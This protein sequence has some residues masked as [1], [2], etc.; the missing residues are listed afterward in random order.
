ML[1]RLRGYLGRSRWR[2]RERIHSL[3]FI[4]PWREWFR[5]ALGEPTPAQSLRVAAHRR[6]RDD[7]AARA[8]R[9]GQDARG[10]PLGDRPARASAGARPKQPSLRVLYVSPLKAL[11]VDVERNLRAPLAGI[12]RGGGAARR[13]AAPARGR[14]AHRRH[15]RGGARADAARAAGH[16]HHDAGVALPAAHL[17]AARDPRVGRHGHHRRDPPDGREQ[18]RRAPVPVA[19]AA[20]RRCG[21]TRRLQR[22][23]LSAT[24]RPLD[25]IARLL[26]GVAG[27]KAKGRAAPRARRRDRR[28]VGEEG[29]LDHGRGAASPRPTALAAAA[30]RRRRPTTQRGAIWPQVHARLVERIRAARSTMIFVNSRRLAERLATALNETAG[31]EIA[32][33]HHGSVAKETPSRDRGAAQ[34]RRPARDRRH[35]V[36]RARHRHGR[37]RSGHPDRGAAVGRVGHPAHRPRE[38]PRRRRAL[39]RARPEAQARS[40]GVRR[41]RRGHRE[42]RRRGDVLRAQ[43]ARR[44]R[45]ADRRDRRGRHPGAPPRREQAEERKKEA[46]TSESRGRDRGR[47]DLG[48]RASRRAVRG[49]PARAAST[50]CSTCSPAAT[51]ATSSP[52]SGRAS[53]GTAPRGVDHAARGREAPRDPE[54]AA[55]S[56]IAASTACSSRTTPA[57]ATSEVARRGSTQGASRRRRVGELDEEMVFELREGEVFLLGASSW[58]AEQI[59]HDRVLVTPAAGVPGKMPFWHGDRAGRTRRVR[60]A[61]RRAH[62]RDRRAGA[63]RSARD[64]RARST[65]STR[66]PPTISSPTCTSRRSA[67]GDVPSDSTIVVERVPDELGD[68]RVCVLSPFGSRVH[69]PWAMAALRRLRDGARGRHRGGVVRRRHRLP[70]AGRRGAAADRAAL[71]VARR[72]RG[73][74]HARARRARRSSPRAFARPR[75]ARCSCRA[76]RIG[77]RTPL[78]AQRKRAA[79][80]LAVAS[81]YP[82][83]PDRARDVP[84]VPARRVR[85]ARR[86]STCCE[87]SRRARS[88]SPPSTL[89]TPSPFAASL[90]FSFVGNFIYDDDAPLAERRAQALTIDHA[91][92]RELLG[93]AELR[94]L[95]DPDVVL[96]HEPTAAAARSPAASRRRAARPARSGSA[97]WTTT[98]SRR[99]DVA[100]SDGK[101][102]STLPR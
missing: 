44:A 51:R 40:P 71:P 58:R 67:A 12:V 38:P 62:A 13:P 35:V 85:S 65:T 78:W 84:R 49:A 69:A 86:S 59:T 54:R 46:S 8:D 27:R 77:K 5:A 68:L 73:R 90:L 31:E 45:A 18:A 17:R 63:A 22:I 50:A 99:T 91:Q 30:R 95:L 98:R 92:L 48:P 57:I 33:A 52:T 29:A 37:G 55:P 83:V 70:R 61:H 87:R 15:A 79:D 97:T 19:R 81:Q 1:L 43:P 20:R 7:A 23:G 64:A 39:G 10:V 101:P 102:R 75:R 34:G 21:P 88:G 4:P 11:A 94:K 93:E 60:H 14:G 96:E 6:G 42:R 24:Q 26:G 74:R 47:S 32:L 16:P 56:P 41:G 3:P 9:L 25:E 80:L 76:D 28:C 2:P 53:P 66:A 82:V 100:A 72:G 89:T 36:A